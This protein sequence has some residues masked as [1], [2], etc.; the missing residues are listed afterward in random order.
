LTS[1][2][3]WSSLVKRSCRMQSLA[4]DRGDGKCLLWSFERRLSES[5]VSDKGRLRPRRFDAFGRGCVKTQN[6]R[7]VGSTTCSSNQ[8][9]RMKSNVRGW[10][11]TAQNE[12]QEFL[13][14]L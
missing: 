7:R 9:S 4:D 5:R 14:G 1:G 12:P 6:V 13:H 8:Q 3:S 10:K 11:C 2:A